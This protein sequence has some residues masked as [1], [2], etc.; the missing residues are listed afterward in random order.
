V[1]LILLGVL[2]WAILRSTAPA[3]SL[4]ELPAVS[5]GPKPQAQ[6]VAGGR[7]KK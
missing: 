1:A 7:K 5:G 4:M 3:P 6:A 2:V